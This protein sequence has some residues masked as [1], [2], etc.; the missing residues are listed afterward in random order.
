LEVAPDTPWESLA[1]LCEM[2]MWVK[3][4]HQGRLVAQ[5]RLELYAIKIND[6]H[7][8]IN[9]S[10][11]IQPFLSKYARGYLQRL[12]AGGEDDANEFA[13]TDVWTIA[14]QDALIGE[15][16]P[17]GAHYELA[18]SFT[19]GLHRAAPPEESKKKLV[20]MASTVGLH[21]RA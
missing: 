14:D 19:R 12:R 16:R 21:N 17:E 3:W 10:P 9:Q 6:L 18:R 20:K 7:E 15:A 2:A 13:A 8:L 4:Q 1:I 11:D 5:T